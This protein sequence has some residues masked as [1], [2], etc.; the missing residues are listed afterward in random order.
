M[1]RSA[2]SL[3]PLILLVPRH[4]GVLVPEACQSPLDSRAL[5]GQEFARPGGIH[6]A[7][8]SKEARQRLLGDVP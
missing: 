3:I 4:A 8:L 2:A 7:T 5:A 6:G 1:L